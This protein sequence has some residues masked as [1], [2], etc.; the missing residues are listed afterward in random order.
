[1][2]YTRRDILIGLAGFGGSTVL[3]IPRL[4]HG[5][6]LV[7]NK[8]NPF[9]STERK[10]LV[11]A[12]DRL[13]PGAVEAGV[14]EYMDYWVSRKTFRF[15][16]NYLSTGA[17][18]LDKIA[19]KRYEISFVNCSGKQQDSIIKDFAA[20]NI[21]LGKFNSRLFFQQLM[22]LTLEGFL[23]DPKY[24]GNRNRTGWQFIGLPDGLRSCWWNP[25]GVQQ[26][27]YPEKG[28]QD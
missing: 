28:F 8:A 3:V 19:L 11:K 23:S 12:V 18:H 27:L 14:P 17:G 9:S 2:Y 25:E 5:E 21:N 16:G 10:I 7:A 1:M 13:L 20:G 15:L 26:V 4:V 22:E 6:V 24:G